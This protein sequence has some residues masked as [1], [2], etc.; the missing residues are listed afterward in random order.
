[1]ACFVYV[2]YQH[3]FY[4]RK[5][6][7]KT[8]MQKKWSLQQHVQKLHIFWNL[9][10]I[11]VFNEYILI[12]TSKVHSRIDHISVKNR[13]WVRLYIMRCWIEIRN[14]YSYDSSISVFNYIWKWHSSHKMITIVHFVDNYY[15]L[16]ALLLTG[17]QQQKHCTLGRIDI[18]QSY[19]TIY[20]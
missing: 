2:F 10:I 9:N 19:M 20:L 14:V 5:S 3:F 16:L 13:P 6:M 12:I 8:H 1:M 4:Y 17:V 11:F 15:H 7:E 18:S